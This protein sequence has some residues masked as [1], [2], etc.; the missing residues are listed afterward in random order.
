MSHFKGQLKNLRDNLHRELVQQATVK[1]F[2]EHNSTDGYI[3][4]YKPF[5]FLLKEFRPYGEDLISDCVVIGVHSS[6]G[7]LICKD[8]NNLERNASYRDLT[9]D[10]L[11]SLHDCIV[12]QQQFKFILYDKENKSTV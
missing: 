7:D 2:I 10:E 1:T 9:V 11:V 12:Y 6:S 8:L 4:L 5:R 3:E